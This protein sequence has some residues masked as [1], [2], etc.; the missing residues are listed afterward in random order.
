MANEKTIVSNID[1]KILDKYIK[2]FT[3]ISK[4][5]VYYQVSIRVKVYKLE[6]NEKG[7]TYKEH[8]IYYF[9]LEPKD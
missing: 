7:E 2:K 5:T 3:S 1:N 4:K 9:N 8:K 6:K